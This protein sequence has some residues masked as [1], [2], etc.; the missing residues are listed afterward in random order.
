MLQKRGRGF[1]PN[2]V[3]ALAV[4]WENFYGALK[5]LECSLFDLRVKEDWVV[6]V[7]SLLGC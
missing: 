2:P 6:G 1:S 5:F 4:D 3:I 7:W